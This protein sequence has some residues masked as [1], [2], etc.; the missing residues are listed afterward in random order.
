MNNLIFAAIEKK[1]DIEV[2]SIY[3]D[4]DNISLD[5]KASLPHTV[6]DETTK[7]KM[8]LLTALSVIEP[9]CRCNEKFILHLPF[10]FLSCTKNISEDNDNNLDNDIFTFSNLDW[11]KE[12]VSY[13]EK[14]EKQNDDENCYFLNKSTIKIYSSELAQKYSI[15][16]NKPLSYAIYERLRTKC[17]YAWRCSECPDGIS[18]KCEGINYENYLSFNNKQQ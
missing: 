6:T 17:D 8:L 14:E 10:D 9:F 18:G 13:S 2:L 3:L 16:V 4:N 15:E 1:N 5:I 11:I 7:N 12:N